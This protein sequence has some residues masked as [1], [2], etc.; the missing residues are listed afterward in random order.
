MKVGG[1]LE[2][3]FRYQSQVHRHTNMCICTGTWVPIYMYAY[4]HA[5]TIYTRIK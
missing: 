5:Y 1:V 2:E 3:E 4:M